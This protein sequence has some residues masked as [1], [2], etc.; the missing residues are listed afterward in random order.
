MSDQVAC[1]AGYA[2][3]ERPQAFHWEGQRHK[4]ERVL[5]QAIRPEGKWFRVLSGDGQIF[6]LLYSPFLDRWEIWQP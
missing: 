4:V 1:H 6:E 2:Y 3:A 5:A